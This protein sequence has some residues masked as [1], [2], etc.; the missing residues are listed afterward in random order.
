MVAAGQHCR[1]GRDG[2][3]SLAIVIAGSD[4]VSSYY[5]SDP[6]AY[7]ARPM[8]DVL[9]DPTNTEVLGRHLL[10]AAYERHQGCGRSGARL[11]FMTPGTLEG[12]LFGGAQ[13]DAALQRLHDRMRESSGSSASSSGGGGGC[14]GRTSCS[15]IVSLG[16]AGGGSPPGRRISM[17]VRGSGVARLEGGGWEWVGCDGHGGGEPD[18]VWLNGGGSGDSDG[19]RAVISGSSP[20]GGRGGG[21]AATVVVPCIDRRERVHPGAIL[22]KIGRRYRVTS[23]DMG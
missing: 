13:A 11:D 3:P 16:R 19:I 10:R 9:V 4:P 21:E 8:E 5:I 6:A 20:A 2:R 17:A 12:R 1:S 15:S 22:L 7:M 14:D 23:I 18:M